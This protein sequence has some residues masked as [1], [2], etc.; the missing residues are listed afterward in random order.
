LNIKQNIDDYLNKRLPEERYTSF[1]YCFN[2]F[3]SFCEK[4]EI[5]EIASQQ[6]IQ[7]SCFQLG[8]YLASWGMFRGS[9]FLIKKS[10]KHFEKLIR[11]ISQRGQEYWEIDV[12]KY[13]D[14]NIELL[15]KLK[16]DI[17]HY[18][19]ETEERASSTLA[20]KIIL[21]VFGSVPAIDQNVK[22]AFGINNF[23]KKAL[24]KFIDFYKRN[25]S[26]IDSCKIKTLDFFTGKETERYYTKA[27]IIDMVGFIEGGKN[28]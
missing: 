7:M 15:L 13:S 2:Y 3:R 26:L 18:L 6:N 19:G 10:V 16:W 8:F 25:T 20:T 22:N 24:E 23:N 21:G 11:K 27:K 4:N 17:E 1:D 9:S 14:R 28:L 12:D 5:G